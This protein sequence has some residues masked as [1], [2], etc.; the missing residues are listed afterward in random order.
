[1]A[2]YMEGYAYTYVA[3]YETAVSAVLYEPMSNAFLDNGS[4]IKLSDNKDY[5]EAEFLQVKIMKYL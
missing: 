2:L 1:M 3:N 5:F 4:T